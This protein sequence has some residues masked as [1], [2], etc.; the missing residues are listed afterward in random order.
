VADSAIEHLQKQIHNKDDSFKVMNLNQLDFPDST[1]DIVFAFGLLG[2][3]DDPFKSF[4][5]LCR[6]CKPG[7]IIGLFS[8]EITS[9]KKIFFQTLRAFCKG[10]N[11]EQ[12]HRVAKLIIPI[13]GLLPSNSKM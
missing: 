12:K 5:E 9:M 4:K 2:Y 13:Y 7:G 6:V 10:M 3:C 1:F 11:L 8:P